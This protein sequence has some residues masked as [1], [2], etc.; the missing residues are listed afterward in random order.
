MQYY[1]NLNGQTIGPMN[2]DQ[3]MAYPVNSNTPVSR[4]G[5]DWQPLYAFPEL[6]QRIQYKG[7]GAYNSD[8]SAKK[9]LCGILA[10]L[11]GTLGVQYF[12]LGKTAGGLITILLSLVTCGAWGIVTLVQGIL[13]LCMSDQDFEQKYINS[14]STLPLF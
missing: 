5:G 4:D 6:M 14:T 7:S 1:I 3:M 8:I 13:M 10:I 9:T 12:V 11:V 2:I